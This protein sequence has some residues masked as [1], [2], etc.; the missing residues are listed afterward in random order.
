MVAYPAAEKPR[1]QGQQT[2]YQQLLAQGFM[3]LPPPPQQPQR[4]QTTL[5]PPATGTLNTSAQYPDG[6]L[7][8]V[9]TM[10]R[11][12]I[13]PTWHGT[14][15]CI[16]VVHSHLMTTGAMAGRHIYHLRDTNNSRRRR[17]LKFQDADGRDWFDMGAVAAAYCWGYAMR[18]VKAESGGY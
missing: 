10:T 12:V 1:P 9:F 4:P 3:L 7:V 16:S 2:W 18:E 14:S 17:I 11:G 15:G 8:E 6:S 5:P 13:A